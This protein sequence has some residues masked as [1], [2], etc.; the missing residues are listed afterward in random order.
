MN[1]PYAG[2]PCLIFMMMT[3][4]LISVA[5]F[6]QC[7]SYLVELAKDR[8]S[9]EVWLVRLLGLSFFGLGLM[10]FLVIISAWA[11]LLAFV[12]LISI[13]VLMIVVSLCHFTGLYPPLKDNVIGFKW[14]LLSYSIGIF[15]LV[16]N[17]H[18]TTEDVCPSN[19]NISVLSADCDIT[20]TSH[21]EITP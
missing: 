17:T 15:V 10:P 16:T 13:G 21:P 19:T 8:P 4:L 6:L 2:N 7:K 18:T 14:V 1:N 11:F 3:V 9:T 20:D 5:F 12:C